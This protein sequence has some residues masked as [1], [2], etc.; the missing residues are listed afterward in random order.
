V[1]ESMGNAATVNNPN[2]SRF[3]KFIKIY[4]L[5]E[6]TVVGGSISTY[7]LEKV[8]RVEVNSVSLAMRRKGW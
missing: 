1:F 2:S 5:E 3:G 6:G 7:L 8:I 4:M